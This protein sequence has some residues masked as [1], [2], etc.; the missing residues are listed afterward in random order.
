MPSS[1][2][3]LVSRKP[4]ASRWGDGFTIWNR[5]LHYYLGLYFLFFLWLFALTGLLLNH[6]SWAFAQFFANRQVTRYERDIQ[7]PA[8]GSDL[9]Q[10]RNVMAQLGIEGEVA[11]SG[12]RPD[13]SRLDFTASR[14]GR[15]FQVQADLQQSRAA[16]MLTEYNL[17]G[18]LRT[19]H[20]FVGVSPDDP[21]NRRDWL[22]TTVWAIS[23]DA[24]A[25]GVVIMVLG[26]L[27]MWWGLREKRKPGLAA[28]LLGMAVCGLFVFG[29][30]WL[31]S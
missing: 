7:P 3:P 31:Y 17:W 5:K 4:R 1:V 28:L 14:P 22:L 16:V 8:P 24:V 18:V 11:W 2:D 23:M 13:A 6:S 25:A 9:D 15:I 19:L 12:L 30:R 20:T 29:L 10:A 27:Y 21:R 26:G